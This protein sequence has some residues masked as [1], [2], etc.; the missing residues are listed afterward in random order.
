LFWE[1]QSFGNDDRQ[2]KMRGRSLLNVEL[3]A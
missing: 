1:S 2:A 3:K